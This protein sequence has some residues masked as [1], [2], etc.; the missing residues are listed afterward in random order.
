MELRVW[1]AC[2]ACYND[3]KLIGDWIDAADAPGDMDEWREAMR[4]ADVAVPATHDADGHE[5]LWSLD[6]EGFAELG[7]RG[8]MSPVTAREIAEA[9]GDM[10]ADD[11]PALAAW[12]AESSYTTMD[13]HT[14]RAFRDA[15]V[16]TF[17]SA[18][19]YAFDLIGELY[20]EAMAALPDEVRGS[21]DWK[22]VAHQMDA[23]GG[24]FA[25][26]DLP[27]GRVAVWRDE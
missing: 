20:G 14:V 19:E 23:N 13:W 24:W 16:G 7:I 9:V 27:N 11:A 22:H 12:Y 3:G 2:L 1:V 4:E 25:S 5:E 8:E 21:I 18:W 10:D 26:A 6:T 17:D 15:Y